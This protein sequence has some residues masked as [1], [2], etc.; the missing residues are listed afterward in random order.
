MTSIRE[1]PINGSENDRLE[2]ALYPYRELPSE[3]WPEALRL[4]PAGKHQLDPESCAITVVERH[5]RI[6]ACAAA[7]TV[8]HGDE[9]WIAP[10]YR[11]NPVVARQLLEGFFAMCR[12]R[13]LTHV[14]SVA[15]TPQVAGF[16]Q[17]LGG[18]LMGA[19]YLIPIPE[20][21]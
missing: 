18:D 10:E 21:A 13:G 1:V 7:L 16:L 14:M 20:E 4:L 6:I 2:R 8:V 9:F 17:Q 15:P 3:A 5:G 11:G 12:S 19:L